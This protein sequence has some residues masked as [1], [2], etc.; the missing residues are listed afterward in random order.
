MKY[1]IAIILTSIIVCVLLISCT[2]EEPP[3]VPMG[4]PAP[5]ELKILGKAI[6][7][8]DNV[9]LSR[10]TFKPGQDWKYHLHREVSI[11]EKDKSPRLNKGV[12]DGSLVLSPID[13]E[14]AKFNLTLRMAGDEE[15]KP[16]AVSFTIKSNG[17]V[18]L[19]SKAGQAALQATVDLI[20][21]LLKKELTTGEKT[22]KKLEIP[23][24]ADG[25]TKNGSI[26]TTLESYVEVDGIK[27]AVL[28]TSF[29]I[30]A[31]V[32]DRAKGRI[33]QTTE[34]EGIAYYAFEKGC[35]YRSELLS[36]ETYFMES[37]KTT[38]IKDEHTI[39]E[40]EHNESP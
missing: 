26:T 21:P 25:D 3:T 20:L 29:K 37:T 30:S 9:T 32:T 39:L 22:T 19:K 11:L 15:S 36:R 24:N 38:T 4:N 6:E 31:T 34:G 23:L 27:C 7:E 17:E 14:N 33:T 2:E 13:G 16:E 40:L 35:F 18:S 8:P 1:R 12:T 10:W 28:R 5:P